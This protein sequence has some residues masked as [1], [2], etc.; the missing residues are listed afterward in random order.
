[1]DS[2]TPFPLDSTARSTQRVCTW[3]HSC[4]DHDGDNTALPFQHCS[5]AAE[6]AAVPC[7][8]TPAGFWQ[9]KQ[10]AV[11]TQQAPSLH[12]TS[13]CLTVVSGFAAP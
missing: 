1:M 4:S 8:L 7:K 9:Q 13:A 11:S 3:Y 10:Q 5:A 12:N 6:Q 2:P